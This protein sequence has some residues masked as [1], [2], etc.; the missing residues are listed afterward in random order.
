MRSGRARGSRPPDVGSRKRSR[1]SSSPPAGN[2]IGCGVARAPRGYRLSRL[3]GRRSGQIAS[4]SAGQLGEIDS[5]AN[6]ACNC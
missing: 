1:S 6:E 2:S 4:V 5:L 3:R